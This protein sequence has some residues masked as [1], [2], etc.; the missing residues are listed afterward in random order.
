MMA[1]KE[2]SSG[3]IQIYV[4]SALIAG[5]FAGG[6][7]VSMG[8]SRLLDGCRD[9]LSGTLQWGLLGFCAWY[10]GGGVSAEQRKHIVG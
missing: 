2:A 6:L 5:R 4:P 3:H 8:V 9:I 10:G 1:T 7:F